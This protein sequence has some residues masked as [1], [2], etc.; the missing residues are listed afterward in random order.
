MIAYNGFIELDYW[1]PGRRIR[2]ASRSPDSPQEVVQLLHRHRVSMTPDGGIVLGHN[3]MTSYATA[4][5]NVI[6]DIVA[7][8]GD[9]AS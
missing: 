7:G 3:T 8:Q 9:T 4:D 5:P 2:S 6:L 1:W